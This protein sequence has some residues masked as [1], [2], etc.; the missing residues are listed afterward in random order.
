V[1]REARSRLRKV[2]TQARH[3]LEEDIRTQLKRLGIEEVGETIPAGRLTHL[4]R[5]DKEL[6]DK[7]LLA[8]QK[9][10]VRNVKRSEAYDRYVRHVD[11]TYLNR[12]AALRAMEVRG[13]ITETLIKRDQYAGMSRREYELS[14]REGLSDLTEITKRSLLEAFD[15]VSQE[16]KVLFDVNDEYSLLF[17]SPRSLD[18]LM[19]LL[20]EEVPEE[21]WRE[22]DI[23]GWIYQYYNSEA[24]SEFRKKRRKPRP[25]DIPVINQFYTPRWLVRALVDNTLGRLWL[26][27]KG[28]IPET[29][30]ARAPSEE[31]LRNPQGETVDEYCSYLVPLRQDPLP[32]EKKRVRE[33]KVL[34]PACGSGH[35]LVHA[36]NVLYRMYLEDE[37]DTPREEIPRLILEN[38]LFGID[39]DLRSVQLA[40]LSLF[41]KA[42]EYDR[43]VR[44][45]KMNLVCADVR[46]T[47]GDLQK[48]FISRLEHDMDLQRIFAKLFNEFEY[49]YD[50]GSLL[51]VRAPFERL[52]EER[53]KG[54]QTRFRPR[55]IGQSSLSKKGSVGG[56]SALLIEE[57]EKGVLVKPAVTLEEMLD[58]LLEFEREG[59]EK[60]DMGTMLFAAE[61]EK[62]VGLLSLLSQKYDV[63]VM[64]PPYGKMPQTTK[65]YLREH[66]P[67]TYSDYYTAF[68]EQTTDLCGINGCIGAL[69]GRTFMFLK[70]HQKLREE[71]L[72]YDALPEVFLDLGFNVLDEAV[73]R[74]AAF[75]LRK[76]QGKNEKSWKHH[77]VIFFKLTDYD[78]D[79]KKVKFEE[80]I[81][82]IK[83]ES[84][85]IENSIYIV[86][87]GE[88]ADVP[89]SPYSYWAPKLLRDLFKKYPPLDRDVAKH[90]NKPKI[91]DVNK[92]M[93]TGDD[94]RFTRFWWEVG[95][96]NIAS[97]SIETKYK[98]WVPFAK[99]GG[100]F[101]F[102]VVFVIDWF[103]NGKELKEYE[104]ANIRNEEF[105]FREGLIW[106]NKM[107]WG[108][109][110]ELE[111]L[112]ISKLPKNIIFASGYN[113]IFADNLWPL[114]G[115]GRSTLCMIL[116]TIL[117][118]NIQNV[119]VGVVARLPIN[120]E[121]INDQSLGLLAKE[122]CWLL[123][124]WDTGNETSTQFVL[125]W[126][127]QVWKGFDP[128]WKPITQHPLVEDFAWSGF[129]AA[130]KIREEGKKWNEGP[131]VLSLANKCLDREK[132]LRERMQQ[133]QREI[134]ERVYT[135]YGID[136]D[137]LPL[138]WYNE[139]AVVGK[140]NSTE[141]HVKRLVSYYIKKAIESDED[142]IVLL[143]ELV[144]S[145]R[146]YIE[147]DFGKNEKE[148]VD[149]EISQVLGK[150][151]AQWLGDD[152]FSFHVGLYGRRPIIWHITSAS[153]SP[154]RGS[155][156]T[157]N[158]FVYYHKLSKDIIPKIRARREYLRG[159]LDGA[160][161]KTERLRRELQNARD[162]GDKSKERQ[163]Q[164]E[165]E[166]ALDEFNELQAFDN[167]L[168][169]V[170]NP[171]EDRTQL[172]ED[173]RWLERK[174]AEVR[175]DGWNPV[176]DYGVR[177]NIEPLKEA[178]LLHKAVY[179]VN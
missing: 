50:I 12:L 35:F 165:Y 118:P 105:F 11:F 79:E 85:T 112:K 58:A 173:A 86:E 16:I 42:K 136:A 156:G 168:A 52:L 40:A 25:D 103:R 144:Q 82:E 96:N 153:F 51:K 157:F 127:L 23:I 5:E 167:K 161:W 74:Y 24:R 26:E 47:D 143:E 170:S 175:D 31:R 101:Y 84:R 106:V 4:R 102:D 134:N 104:K 69:T 63:V 164:G 2:V 27:M 71:I 34:D 45:R 49:T 20:G 93:D 67:V 142:G 111:P 80:S 77:P 160:K 179:R 132:Q 107:S 14:E 65:N 129:L 9:E 121:I 29:G 48:K 19:S 78:W 57:R 53:R 163:L 15:E 70:S 135:I 117:D 108:A 150:D 137:E 140:L 177:V 119:N 13:L 91:A 68:V 166:E 72:R 172:D 22:E 126:P 114:L 116:I 131:S 36:F 123:R 39:I 81:R 141:E 43:D 95:I 87:L 33:I 149:L 98:K 76:R 171:R 75:T 88:L 138:R 178:G 64:N 152:Y 159:V 133:I 115:W 110:T 44:I 139:K 17:P 3:L 94:K 89:G 18:R 1:D 155:Y 28:R 128:S 130:K 37:P 7:I 59:M 154:R 148:K 113:A 62:S 122:A 147:E 176:I 97:S 32:R 146:K 100:S 6:R 158:C 61:A 54:V 145:I 90:M 174:I 55:I 30:K 120:L 46:I 125:P 169:E 60:K 124:E 99:G 151:L 56:Q 73:A 83:R 21:D 92:G 38:N 10:Q 66:Y 109:A 162:S 41:L 8:I